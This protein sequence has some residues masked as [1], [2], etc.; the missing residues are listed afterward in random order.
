MGPKGEGDCDKGRTAQRT[1]WTESLAIASKGTEG[2]MYLTC[3]GSRGGG[4]R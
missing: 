3:L 2:E 1:C 4:G